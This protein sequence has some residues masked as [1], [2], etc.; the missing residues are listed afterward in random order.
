MRTAAATAVREVWAVRL[1]VSAWC[2]RSSHDGT[3]ERYNRGPRRA[4]GRCR[5]KSRHASSDQSSEVRNVPAS[6]RATPYGAGRRVV[7]LVSERL[8]DRRS[9][10]W[11]DEDVVIRADIG[12]AACRSPAVNVV[13][14]ESRSPQQH[15]AANARAL[16]AS[17]FA[18]R[19]RPRRNSTC[20]TWA[21]A[22]ERHAF[23]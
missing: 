16:Q 8:R 20:C 10:F 12:R 9:A 19:C 6:S 22:D 21:S 7:F 1:F 13:R 3:Y 23:C 11:H 14:S 4:T 2:R 17:R 18:K 15:S 5:V